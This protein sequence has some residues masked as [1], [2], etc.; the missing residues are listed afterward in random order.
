VEHNK[1]GLLVA[2]D[3]DALAKGIGKVLS[4]PQKMK[5]LSHQALRKA[6]TFDVNELGKRILSV[7]E[8]AIQDKKDNQYVTLSVEEAPAQEAVSAT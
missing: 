8:Q 5:R 4:D 3:V 7:Y 1:Q 2:N 6:K